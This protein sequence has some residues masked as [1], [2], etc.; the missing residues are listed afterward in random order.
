MTT[1]TVRSS[2]SGG[3]GRLPCRGLEA[4]EQVGGGELCG[5]T[6]GAKA[7]FCLAAAEMTLAGEK[8]KTP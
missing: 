5:R 2:G 3:A 4:P 8:E 1:E 7:L 6:T